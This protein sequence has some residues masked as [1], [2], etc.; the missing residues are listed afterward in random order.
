M[1]NADITPNYYAYSLRI[2][3]NQLS[4]SQKKHFFDCI[5]KIYRGNDKFIYRGDKK[6]K[7]QLLYGVSDNHFEGDFPNSMFTL[8]AKARMFIDS[9]LP[10]TNE[11]GIA[12]AGNNVFRLIFQMLSKL[13]HREFP[14]GPVRMATVGFRAR[15]ENVVAFF[16]NQNNEQVFLDI[17]ER[18]TPQQ[19]IIIRDYYLAL[20]HH[21]SKSEYYA[22]S[23]LLSTTSNFSQAYRFAWKGE[24]EDSRNP[25][26]LFGWVPNQY[27]GVLSVPNSRIL[28]R[29]IDMEAIGLPVY[30]RSFFPNQEEVTLKGGLLPHYFLGYLHHNSEEP[31]V[32]EINPALLETDNLWDG[33]EL[34][35]DQSTF[36]QRIQNTLFGRYFTIDPNSNQYRQDQ[37]L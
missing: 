28:K 13:L 31:N 1:K 10:G 7:L 11:I 33:R 15:E 22:S 21:I 2:D 17:I 20:L 16:R 18:V 32:F 6:D 12:E 8:G 14:F 26:I 34:P 29:K 25:L 9:G 4:D 19:Q 35:I 36:H 3:G 30:E 37:R 23:F 27:E 24:N 5:N